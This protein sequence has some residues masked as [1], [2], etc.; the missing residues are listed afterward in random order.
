MDSGC[1]NT[2]AG[3]RGTVPIQS[4]WDLRLASFGFLILLLIHPLVFSQV[5]AK[6]ASQPLSRFAKRYLVE[7]ELAAE[8]SIE[9]I[10]RLG[11]GVDVVNVRLEQ[12][13]LNRLPKDM[14][15][16][17]PQLV[18]AY[19][20]E[21][22]EG[23][24]LFLLLKR[25]GSGGRL[26]VLHRLSRVEKNYQEKLGLIRSYIDIEKIVDPGERLSAF[27]KLLLENLKS[28]SS[29]TRWNSLYELRGLHEDQAHV[30]SGDE[31]A[32]IHAV[33]DSAKEGGFRTALTAFCDALAGEAQDG[34][35]PEE[36]PIFDEKAKKRQD[37][38]SNQRGD[39][40][41]ETGLRNDR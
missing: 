21:Y 22:K 24:R 16:R 37:D 12:V 25:Y 39:D 27:A 17:N 4:A 34:P 2:E 30:F 31:T 7:T 9:R 8:V 18:L 41:K 29:W 32:A 36:V 20:N 14:A 13:F 10:Y 5:N 23:T 6:Q 33:R 11:M 38:G 15:K 28:R 3:A 26:T 35:L 19:R 40:S 1:W